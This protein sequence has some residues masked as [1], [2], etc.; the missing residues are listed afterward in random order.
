MAALLQLRYLPNLLTGLRLVLIPLLLW[1]VWTGADLWASVK[2]A[3]NER[4]VP[5]KNNEEP[6]QPLYPHSG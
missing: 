5:K 4:A 3:W 1:L 2:D 6:L